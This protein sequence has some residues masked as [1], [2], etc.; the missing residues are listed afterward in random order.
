MATLWMPITEPP[1]PSGEAVNPN[2]IKDSEIG[3]LAGIWGA[4]PVI[5]TANAQSSP[6]KTSICAGR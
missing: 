4:I 6:Q 1:V 2:S 3:L 5:T